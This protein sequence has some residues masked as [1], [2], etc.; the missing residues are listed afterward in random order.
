M[1]GWV[2]DDRGERD[3]GPQFLTHYTGRVVANLANADGAHMRCRFRLID[4]AEGVAGGGSGACELSNGS[5]IHAQFP[6][7]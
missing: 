2:D 1:Y 7:A 6:S 3:P 5:P 4:P